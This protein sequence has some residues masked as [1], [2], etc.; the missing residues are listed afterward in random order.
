MRRAAELAAWPGVLLL[1]LTSAALLGPHVGDDVAMIS[2]GLITAAAI[3]VLE[4]LLPFCA[5]WNDHDGEVS[6]D[7]THLVMLALT[8]DWTRGFVALWAARTLSDESGALS[9]ALARWWSSQ[10]LWL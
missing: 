10:P 9:P 2:T 1:A 5:S 3:F 4:R 6:T 7:A 8:D